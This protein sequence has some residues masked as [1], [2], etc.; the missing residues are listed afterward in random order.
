MYVYIQ[1][2]HF[3]VQ[4]KL[5]QHCKA[6]IFQKNPFF[7][8]LLKTQ[9]DLSPAFTVGIWSNSWREIPPCSGGAPL[10][11][12]PLEFLTLRLFHT[13]PPPICQ[14]QFVFSHPTLVPIRFLLRVSA[15]VAVS[16]VFALI[17]ILAGRSCSVS[18]PL[19][20]PRTG[21]DFSVCSV[22]TCSWDG[23]LT[24]SLLTCGIRLSGNF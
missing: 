16:P 15:M 5:T 19:K 10:S 13:E 23:A 7:F 3:V 14:L 4:Q 11:L 17:S 12:D 1:L 9:G 18:S 24:P 6:I 8:P 2:I 22:F 21:V 20:D